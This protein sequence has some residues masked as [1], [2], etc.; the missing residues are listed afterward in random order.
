MRIIILFLSLPLL[1]FCSSDL[2]DPHLIVLGATGTGKSS[3]ANVLLGESPDCQNCTFPVCSGPDSCTKET[4][5]AEGCWVGE[6][7]EFTIVDTPGFGDS[8][9]DDNNLINEMVE[10]LKNVVKTANGFLLL[11]NGQSERFDSKAQQMIREMEAL[12]GPGFWEHV[13]LGVSF[14]HYDLNS[15]MGRNNSGKTESWWTDQMNAQ[16]KEKFHL[17]NDLQ[18]VFIDSWAKQEWNLADALQQ[19]AFDRETA[20][21]WEIFSSN[22]K[23]EFKTIQDVI[24]DLNQCQQENECLTGEIQEKLAQQLLFSANPF[25]QHTHMFYCQELDKRAVDSGALPLREPHLTQ[26]LTTSIRAV[27]HKGGIRE[28]G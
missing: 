23:F 9:N 11:F 16:L 25:I 4:S 2:I 18:A 3:I 8:D 13:I 7:S 19:E 27:F 24:D 12:F 10:A 20:K 14:W 28:V 5:Y 17:E 1:D 26:L 22:S 21:L 6:G 15:I